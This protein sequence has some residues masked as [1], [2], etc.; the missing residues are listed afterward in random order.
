EEAKAECTAIGFGF[1]TSV[2]NAAL[3][4]GTSSHAADYDHS[5]GFMG[6]PTSPVIPAVFSLAE[7]HGASGRRLLEA[8]AAGVEISARLAISGRRSKEPKAALEGWHPNSTFGSFG[9]AIACA[10]LSGLDAEKIGMLLGITASMASGLTANY[11]TMSKPLN[12]GLAARNG[13]MAARLAQAGFTANPEAF[14]HFVNPMP[15]DQDP[16]A[17][18]GEVYELARMGIRVKPYPC[19]GVTHESIDAVLAARAKAPHSV[20][21]I[22]RSVDAIVR[23]QLEVAQRGYELP[24]NAGFPQT[25]LEAKFSLP[26]VTARAALDGEVTPRAFTEAAI[27][28]P[29]VLA[30]IEHVQVRLGEGFE[31]TADKRPARATLHLKDGRTLSHQVDHP[32]GGIG[33]PMTADEM[34]AKFLGCAKGVIDEAVARTAVDYIE[35]LEAMEDMRPLAKLLA[36]SGAA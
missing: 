35:N 31:T 25:P 27:R 32:K 33:T 15:E 23:I 28:D 11:G 7:C 13:V 12:V 14:N 9:A 4:N 5:F 30:L 18:L 24:F 20:D 3:V 29:R 6:Q 22:E 36:G 1:G 19:G 16:F 17:N 21:A 2:A 26:Y 10:K 8:Y 34:R